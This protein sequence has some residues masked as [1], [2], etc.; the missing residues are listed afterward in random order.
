[1]KN[2]PTLPTP[3]D[4]SLRLGAALTAIQ[5]IVYF[6]FILSC[7]FFPTFMATSPLNIGVPMSF[8]FGLGVIGCGVILTIV[9]VGVSNRSR[10]V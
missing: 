3:T 9:Y 1:M 6:A 8:V 2:A 7:S 4:E 5:V 10:S